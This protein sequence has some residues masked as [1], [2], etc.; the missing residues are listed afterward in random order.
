M[1]NYLTDQG[2]ELCFIQ[3]QDV[4]D[5]LWGDYLTMTDEEIT[6]LILSAQNAVR[7][8]FNTY[9]TC[10]EDLDSIEC[11][12]IPVD[13]R[14]A[15]LRILENINTLANTTVSTTQEIKSEKSCDVEIEYYESCGSCVTV[16]P[17]SDDIDDLLCQY[18]KN[19]FNIDLFGFCCKSECLE[20]ETDC[21]C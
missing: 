8:W 3:I 11:A 14:R 13:I 20:C 4:K 2:G 16:A 12:D 9:N 19:S 21:Q 1:T 18:K 15:T 10:I 7:C 6:Q 5:S 17:I